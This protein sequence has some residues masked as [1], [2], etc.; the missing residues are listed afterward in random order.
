MGPNQISRENVQRKLVVQSNVAGRDVGGVVKDIQERVA[1]RVNFPDGYYVEYGGQFE[2]AET[3]T[4]RITWLSLLSLAAIYLLLYAEF[5][6]VRQ[7]LLVM[8]NLPLALVGGVFAILLTDGV[9]NVAT[10]V[11]FITLFGIAVRN[12]ILMVSH[13]NHLLAEGESLRDA[14][15]RGS[16]ERLSPIF[17]TALTAGLALLPLALSGGEPGNEIQSPLAIVV[18]GGL[19]TSLSL[20]MIVVPVLFM[21]FGVSGVGRPA[22]PPTS[23]T[24]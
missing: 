15:V 11:G 1:A 9:L 5:R 24:T 3:A 22:G 19:L 20:N 8:V 23:M 6:T 18:L 2:S 12:G 14:V 13:Y 17:M 7:S 4:R 21:R 16:M 10:L